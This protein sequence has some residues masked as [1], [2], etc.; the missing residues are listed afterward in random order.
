ME[1]RNVI[2]PGRTPPESEDKQASE[3]V[4]EEHLSKRAAEAV[5]E[6]F[7]REQDATG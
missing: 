3:E 5:Q 7:S 1:K 6:Q 4:L 2:E